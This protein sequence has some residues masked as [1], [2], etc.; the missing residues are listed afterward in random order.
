MIFYLYF[1]RLTYI[2]S[3]SFSEY[4]KDVICLYEVMS[5]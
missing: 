3:F 1:T 4:L 5:I 2:G